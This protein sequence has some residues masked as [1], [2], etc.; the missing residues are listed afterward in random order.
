MIFFW[1]IVQVYYAYSNFFFKI[2]HPSQNSS[3]PPVLKA[4][5]EFKIVKVQWKFCFYGPGNLTELER[6]PECRGHYSFI[7]FRASAICF[8]NPLT[9][10][11]YVGIMTTKSQVLQLCEV[12]IYSRGNSTY[13]CNTLSL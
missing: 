8:I 7:Q 4:L 10:G 12:E 5:G 13:S 11:R 6:N 3:G 9:T 2:T 1:Y